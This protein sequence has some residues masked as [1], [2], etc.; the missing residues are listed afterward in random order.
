M[1]VFF[2]MSCLPSTSLHPPA[3]SGIPRNFFRWGYARNFFRGVFNK[4]SWGQRAERMGIWGGSPLVRGSTQFANEWNPY[5]DKV[6]K[7]RIWQKVVTD[8]IWQTTSKLSRPWTTYLKSFQAWHLQPDER[9]T[10]RGVKD[11]LGRLKSKTVWTDKLQLYW[12]RN[13]SACV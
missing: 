8:R 13:G 9:P 4:F 6:V 11:E 12:K 5:S 2:M 3:G 7:D 10:F 1:L